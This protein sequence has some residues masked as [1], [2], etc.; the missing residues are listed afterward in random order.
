[1]AVEKPASVAESPFKSAKWDEITAG[2]EFRP[3]D[4]PVLAML[5]QWYAVMEQ[6]VEDM[7]AMGGQLVYENRM[8]D[9]KPLP[10]LDI[11]KKASAEIRALS[12]QLCIDGEAPA[13]PQQGRVVKL[14][15]I[16]QARQ[17]KAAN[18]RGAAAG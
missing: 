10:Q 12:K 15:V 16:R 14:D 4:A 17:S 18:R 6:C 2:R 7:D 8:E 9:M 11:M 1:M 13:A 5:C 3:C